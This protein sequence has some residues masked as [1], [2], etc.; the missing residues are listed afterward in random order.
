[1][2]KT[3]GAG[4]FIVGPMNDMNRD[5]DTTLE[6]DIDVL[7]GVLAKTADLLQGVKP[8]Q[9]SQPTPCPEYDV[10]ALMDHMVGWAQVFGAG[11]NGKEFPED[12]ANHRCGDDPAEEFRAAAKDVVEGWSTYG[13]DRTVKVSS[14]ESPGEMVF[15]MTLM[16]YLTHGWDLA[17][18]T[19]QRVP[20]TEAEAAATLARAEVTLPPE[21]RGDGMP[22]AAPV[23]VPADASALD[24][25]VGFMGRD[26]QG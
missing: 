12:P 24:R 8:E 18:A 3:G 16:E 11:S 20:F 14:G 22:F 7:D 15:N 25:L 23:D 10:D 6:N 5:N 17:T 2:F 26:P 1:M 19:G 4:C 21:Y 13:L 9:R